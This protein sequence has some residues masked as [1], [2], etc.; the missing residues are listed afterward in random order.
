[1]ADPVDRSSIS[2]FGL[3]A[4]IV[5]GW[6]TAVEFTSWRIRQAS[7]GRWTLTGTVGRVDV[8]QSRK[9]PLLF[10]AP[11]DKGF[12]LWPIEGD[13]RI[14]NGRLAAWLGPPEQ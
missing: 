5:Y 9:V 1:M 10:T 8:V 12:W 2:L 4:S 11:R 13:V 14:T 7:D 3:K 6:Y